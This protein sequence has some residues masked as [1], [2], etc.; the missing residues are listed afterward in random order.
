MS[1]G[2]PGEVMIKLQ[3]EQSHLDKRGWWEKHFVLIEQFEKMREKAD[4]VMCEEQINP[5]IPGACIT[6]VCFFLSLH[7]WCSLVGRF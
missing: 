2:F 7:E 6:E 5:Q 3:E 1:K 4:W